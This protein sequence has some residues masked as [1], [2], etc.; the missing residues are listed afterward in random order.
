MP[1]RSSR[2]L[3]FIAFFLAAGLVGAAKAATPLMPEDGSGRVEA[4]YFSQENAHF[5]DP[6]RWAEIEAISHRH[7]FRLESLERS[8]E[9]A[10]DV[11]LFDEAGR[12]VGPADY[13]VSTPGMSLPWFDGLTRG[14]YDDENPEGPYRL[15]LARFE[16]SRSLAVAF[17]EGG[18]LISGRLSGGEA[19]VLAGGGLVA[20][21]RSFLVRTKGRE[22]SHAEAHREVARDLGV[23]PENLL[24]LPARRHLDLFL[25]PL[26]GGRVLLD[27]PRLVV[28]TLDEVL[29]QATG[30]ERVRLEALRRF[31]TEGFTP[32]WARS[33]LPRMPY[34]AVELASLDRIAEILS[35]R[36][37]VIRVAGRFSEVDSR[38]SG[39]SETVNFFNGFQGTDASGVHWMVTNQAE[40]LPS[41]ERQWRERIRRESPARPV[42]VYFPGRY[43]PGAGIDCSGAIGR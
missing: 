31:Y 20:R 9:W 1:S 27:D 21:A 33:S 5:K 41:F 2:P 24:E 34:D 29:P 43:T 15:P 35:T 38:K 14:V 30:E 22:V 8:Y 16:H 10:Q 11:A 17:P 13:P 12:F 23:L 26:P 37:E 3:A 32:S 36:L 40:G 4:W 6:R 7:G 25:V 19:Y 42:E 28:P 18:A 39:T